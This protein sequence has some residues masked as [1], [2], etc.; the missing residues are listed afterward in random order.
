[1]TRMHEKCHD[2]WV[3]DAGD[4]LAD[5]LAAVLVQLLFE[6]QQSGLSLQPFL[7]ALR[8]L[9]SEWPSILT[10]DIPLLG[11]CITVAGKSL[12]TL[13]SHSVSGVVFVCFPLFVLHILVA[14]SV[15]YHSTAAKSKPEAEAET[16]AKTTTTKTQPKNRAGSK[17]THVQLLR[18]VSPPSVLTMLFVMN[19]AWHD[20]C[21]QQAIAS[22]DECWMQETVRQPL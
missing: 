10:P 4:R 13:M 15:D 14:C 16:T 1:M 6:A 12:D 8:R 17:F 22:C 2:Q 20:T 3:A 18:A 5:Q 7:A 21:Q 11:A 19:A 9:A